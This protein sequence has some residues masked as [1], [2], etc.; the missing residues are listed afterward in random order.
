MDKPASPATPAR[1]AA[2]MTFC[3]ALVASVW[4]I[5]SD[6]W[7][8]G[9]VAGT[10]WLT[11]AQSVKGLGF[12]AVTSAALFFLLK[13]E[14][15]A[16]AALLQRNQQ[17]RAELHALSQFRASVIESAHVWING[18]DREARVTLWNDAAER[19]TGYRRDEVLGSDRIWQLLYPDPCY[20]R[21]IACE[22]EQI[23]CDG[24]EVQDFE[25][26]IRTRNGEDKVIAW[27]SRQIA[28]ENGCVVGSVAIGRDVTARRAAEQALF[29]RERELTT[30]IA[31][32][33]GMA[34]R[35]LNDT[36][37]T[38]RFV[39]SACLALTGYREEELVDSRLVAWASLVLPED[40]DRLRA[41]V[42]RAIEEGKPFAVEYQL[43]KRSGELVWCWE[44]G[45][46]VKIDG[47]P[48][49][50]GIIVDI[51]ERKRMEQELELM[52]GQDALTGLL[53]RRAFNRIL[54]DEIARATRYNRSFSLLW[55]DL[56]HFKTI[57]DSY[58]HL[59]GDAVLRQVSQL[60]KD[61]LR[62]V[63]CIARY[64]GDEL[65]IILPEMSFEAGRETANRIE[66]LVASS[67]FDV[68]NGHIL[69]LTLSIGVA[70]F[71]EH[72]QGAMELCDAADRA[73]YQ[74][75]K[76]SA[77]AGA[78]RGRVDRL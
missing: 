78:N 74:A 14:W 77:D 59:A 10:S 7:L 53:N 33:P 55:L 29:K 67:R 19:I 66:N 9:R 38:M 64:G 49:L 54:Q 65:T 48:F 23:L 60:I 4:I 57:N 25:T 24:A 42:E 71:P 56:N 72:G 32:L 3:Y 39:S 12:V 50:E 63:D 76:E 45:R 26:T 44:Q 13:R 30:L 37:W 20:R 5:V 11:Q 17:Q 21:R 8:G 69:S 75:K 27:D 15:K 52:A 62:K 41:E 34:Y 28:D 35:C 68:L 22:V 16:D 70:A 43:R 31:N 36:Q 18:L 47:E 73:M 2:R 61:S 58:G 6:W 40:M 46:E 51:T 1:R